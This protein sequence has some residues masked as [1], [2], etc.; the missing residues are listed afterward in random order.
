MQGSFAPLL[1]DP[2]KRAPANIDLCPSQK[3]R[4]RCDAGT[5][6]WL[7]GQADSPSVLPWLAMAE[8]GNRS[9]LVVSSCTSS[10]PIDSVVVQVKEGERPIPPQVPPVALTVPEGD[11]C[12]LILHIPATSAVALRSTARL[13]EVYTC[14]GKGYRYISTLKAKQCGTVLVSGVEIPVFACLGSLKVP[15]KPVPQRAIRLRLLG[16]APCPNKSDMCFVQGLIVR[17]GEVNIAPHVPRPGLAAALAAV[18][19]AAGGQGSTDSPMPAAIQARIADTVVR[20]LEPT[21]SAI[22]SRFDALEARFSALEARMAS[23]QQ[24]A[25]AATPEP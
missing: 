20:R 23:V 15:A 25:G 18:K 12:D 11:F 4:Q 2:L 1:P 7:S 17:V 13:V 16:R 6:A 24:Q 19:G 3:V 22:L 8:S 10:A 5:F 9:G 14:D 21:L